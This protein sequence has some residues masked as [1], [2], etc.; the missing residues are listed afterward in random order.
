MS[1]QLLSRVFNTLTHH[2]CQLLWLFASLTLP[3]LALAIDPYL[4]ALACL[5]AFYL[6][7]PL[8]LLAAL[9]LFVTR[10]DPPLRQMARNALLLSAGATLHLSLH[11]LWV[12]QT[13]WSF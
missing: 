2:L 11:L 5:S 10:H 13:D 6:A 3:W 4:W 8:L 12:V 1:R 9:K 7:L